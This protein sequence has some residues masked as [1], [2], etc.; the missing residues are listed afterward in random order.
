MSLPA[1]TGGIK[2]EDVPVGSRCMSAIGADALTGS[3]AVVTMGLTLMVAA[4]E[5]RFIG[6]IACRVRLLET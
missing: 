2:G 4:V 5:H 6:S 3:R 1:V